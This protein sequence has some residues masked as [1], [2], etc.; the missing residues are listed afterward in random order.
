MPSSATPEKS[1][2]AW[3]SASR[4]E[5]ANAGQMVGAPLN[6]SKR[7]KNRLIQRDLL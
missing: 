6:Q 4:E 5:L 7:A 3:P 1:A 2:A